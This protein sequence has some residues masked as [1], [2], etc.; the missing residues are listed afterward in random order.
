LERSVDALNGS[1]WWEEVLGDDL[2][3]ERRF[4][5]TPPLLRKL[6]QAWR[7]SDPDSVRLS[8]DQEKIW[9]DVYRYWNGRR[10]NPL[11]LVVS[12]GGGAG[13]FLNNR[14]EPDPHKEALRWF[15]ELLLNPEREKLAGPCPRCSNYYIRRSA[16][17][18]VYCSRSCGTRAT[19][20]A[21][22][23]KRRDEEHADKLKRA[24]ERIR[25]WEKSP[26]CDWKA[27]VSERGDISVK[28]LTRAVN[29][30]ELRP[31]TKGKKT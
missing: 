9:A 1:F 3:Q 10:L 18:K 27:F 13:F 29:N 17:N 5:E 15:L 16:R 14:S 4:K 30:G 11:R 24:D 21:A 25:K 23:K 8:R 26:K 6:V 20:L 12:P 19:A 7:F 31:P 28:F 22:T 2:V